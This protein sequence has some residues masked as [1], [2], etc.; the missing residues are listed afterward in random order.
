MSLLFL[1]LTTL[2]LIVMAQVGKIVLFSG[3]FVLNI[4]YE[5]LFQMEEVKGKKPNNR[6]RR[7]LLKNMLVL[8]SFF[9]VLQNGLLIVEVLRFEVAIGLI[10]TLIVGGYT[11]YGLKFI[12]DDHNR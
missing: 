4:W 12:S 2:N 9:I 7:F 10:Q 11:Y 6:T 1:C 5:K 8:L 3:D